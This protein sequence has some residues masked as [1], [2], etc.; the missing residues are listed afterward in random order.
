MARRTPREE[1]RD[2]LKTRKPA[3]WFSGLATIVVIALG[4]FALIRCSDV[5]EKP[6]RDTQYYLKNC[7][8]YDQYIKNCLGNRADLQG[9]YMDSQLDIDGHTVE[10]NDLKSGKE[11]HFTDGQRIEI[12]GE[13]HEGQMI[14]N[15]HFKR[16]LESEWAG[17]QYA[18]HIKLKDE[19][20]YK[21]GGSRDYNRCNQVVID[22]SVRGQYSDYSPQFVSDCQKRV[23][24]FNNKCIAAGW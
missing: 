13:F 11:A 20:T 9:R 2:A 23:D 18:E 3:D 10:V 24:E 1:A 22:A 14:R 4:S 17:T 16:A 15:A 8:E 5:V 12:V 21:P 7:L 19:C 6:V